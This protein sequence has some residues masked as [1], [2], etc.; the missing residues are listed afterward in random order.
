[1]IGL[2]FVGC[3]ASFGDA[4]LSSGIGGIF[5][6]TGEVIPGNFTSK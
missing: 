2:I 1:M 3:V 5:S 4:S 6:E